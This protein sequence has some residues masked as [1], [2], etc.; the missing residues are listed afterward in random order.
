MTLKK[1]IPTRNPK[2]RLDFVLVQNRHQVKTVPL[3][4][5]FLT[6]YTGIIN[7]QVVTTQINVKKKNHTTDIII[8]LSHTH[9]PP[10]LYLSFLQRRN[11]CPGHQLVLEKYCGKVDDREQVSITGT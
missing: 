3:K 4:N 5:S 1:V 2:D 8:T 9:R 11:S 7:K 10:H 6:D